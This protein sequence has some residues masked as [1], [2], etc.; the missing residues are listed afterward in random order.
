MCPQED[1]LQLKLL[2]KKV[3]KSRNW[4]NKSDNVM[5]E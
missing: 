5:L 3:A 1:C 2:G 4:L